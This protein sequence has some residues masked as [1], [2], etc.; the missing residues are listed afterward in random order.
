MPLPA[1]PTRARRA[2]RSSSAAP[3]AVAVAAESKPPVEPMQPVEP[4]G[5]PGF[6]AREEAAI[7]RTDAPA[8]LVRAVAPERN[9]PAG[10]ARGVEGREDPTA[11]KELVQEHAP[12]HSRDDHL[13]DCK[14]GAENSGDFGDSVETQTVAV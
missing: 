12:E 14:Q 7:R 1:V 2:T 4:V 10:M 8:Q 13:Q 9:D 5:N 11:I 6:K 3:L